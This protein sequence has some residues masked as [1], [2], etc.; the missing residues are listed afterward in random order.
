[1]NKLLLQNMNGLLIALLIHKRLVHHSFPVYVVR[2]QLAVSDYQLYKDKL[3][4]RND[5]GEHNWL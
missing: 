4:H 5:A 3:Y 2:T 1:M